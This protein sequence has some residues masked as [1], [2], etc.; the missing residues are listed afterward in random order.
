MLRSYSKFL[1][2]LRQNE[3]AC[4]AN[5]FEDKCHAYKKIAIKYSKFLQILRRNEVACNANCFKDKCHA[6]K[7]NAYKK[8]AI[9][10]KQDY[11]KLHYKNLSPKGKEKRHE[12]YKSYKWSSLEKYN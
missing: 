2:I 6:Y 4:N 7:K 9:K 11:D 8:N 3:V 1:Q 12:Y 5:C 10:Y